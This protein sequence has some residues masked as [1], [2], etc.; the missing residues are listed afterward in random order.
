MLPKAE[1]EN[2]LMWAI[3]A[4]ETAHTMIAQFRILDEILKSTDEDL[5]AADPAKCKKYA[6]WAEEVCADFIALRLLGPSYYFSFASMAI[7]LEPQ[8]SVATHPAPALRLGMMESIIDRHYPGWNVNCPTQDTPLTQTGLVPLFRE[9][10][11]YKE[12]LWR[13][14]GWSNNAR[15][16]R[17]S[18]EMT[19]ESIR[20]DKDVI[21]DVL[22]YVH[23]PTAQ[24]VDQAQLNDI[25]H[26]MLTGQP[27][28]SWERV[29]FDK[30]VFV[31]RL[32]KARVP[33]DVYTIL[34][35]PEDPLTLSSIISSGWML[36]VY[37][38][39]SNL[40]KEVQRSG[41]L[42]ATLENYSRVIH[43]RNLMLQTSLNRSFMMQMY[44]QWKEVV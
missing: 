11:D 31:R 36:K 34:P 22:D 17:S 2:P 19:T 20:F 39:Y 10:V 1:S 3:V 26:T 43:R 7:L 35:P 13:S 21:F 25:Y 12:M 42:Y 15:S 30:E 44:W 23:V 18:F 6:S 27:V 24:F 32:D 28:S 9:L 16:H 5:S 8:R 4:H 40:W 29:G 37:H 14:Q 38:D 33:D 41:S